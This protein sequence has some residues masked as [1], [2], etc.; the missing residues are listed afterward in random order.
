MQAPE[1][2]AR[3]P[4]AGPPVGVG[5]PAGRQVGGASGHQQESAAAGGQVLGD[6]LTTATASSHHGTKD[7]TP[8]RQRFLPGQF[9]HG[10]EPND[11]RLGGH[12]L[13]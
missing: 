9:V 4:H 10:L 7:Y 6:R 2:P 8:A 3:R 12:V 5:T 11:D 1:P 13:H